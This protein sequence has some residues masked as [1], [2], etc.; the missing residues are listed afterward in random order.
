MARLQILIL[1]AIDNPDGTVTTPFALVLDDVT[2]EQAASFADLVDTQ[3]PLGAVG[4]LVFD[5][6]V[7]LF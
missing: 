5:F 2:P 4:M 1:P 3:P 6:P 7:E